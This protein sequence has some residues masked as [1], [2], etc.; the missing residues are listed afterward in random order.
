MFLLVLA[1]GAVGLLTSAGLLRLHLEIMPLRYLI[2]VAVAYG[3]FLAFVWLWII[4][5]QRRWTRIARIGGIPRTNA[6]EIE[7]VDAEPA[8]R[9]PHHGLDWLDLFDGL[10]ELA[11]VA[12]V[13]AAVISILFVVGYFISAIAFAPDFMAEVFL[14]GV[15]T[16]ALYR[17]LSR[18]EHRHWVKSAFAR[19]RAP[20]LWTLLF[21]AFAGGVAHQ[22]APE[23]VSVGGVVRHMTTAFR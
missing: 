17:R 18:I 21:F 9:K 4:F 12:L 15:F 7:Q 2:S 19:T 16:A 10:D 1:T 6:V 11:G 8:A 5:Q 14:D 13:L 22:Y 23:A 20:F 3:A